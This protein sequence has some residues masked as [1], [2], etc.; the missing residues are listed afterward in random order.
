MRD[1]KI[2]LVSFTVLLV[3]SLLVPVEGHPQTATF[4]DSFDVS[5]EEN[6]VRGFAFSTDGTKMFVVG[7]SGDDVNEYTCTAFDVSTCV[8]V[9]SFDVS[10]QDTNPLDVAFS[11][12]GTTMIVLGLDGGDV[13]EYTLGTGFDV[14]TAA[15]VD[16]FII[17]GQEA[18]PTG[19]EFSTDGTT[20]FIVGSAV[21]ADVDEY[22]LGTG[23]D[24]ST[25]AFVDSFDVSGDDTLPTGL[26][27]SA[28]GTIMFVIGDAN[29]LVI[30]YDLGT[31]F[32]VSTTAPIFDAFDVTL[33]TI[34]PFD[35]EFSSD[36]KKMFVL[37]A[38][39]NFV[40]EYTVHAAFDL[41]APPPQPSSEGPTGIDGSAPTLGK[42]KFGVQLVENGFTF[43]GESVDVGRLYTDF[44]LISTDVGKL[45]N[46]QVKIFEN[47]GRGHIK[48]VEFA[49]GIPEVG[50]WYDAEAYIEVWIEQGG[51]KIKALKIFD[52]LNI[53]D[54]VSAFIGT[55]SCHSIGYGECLLV[56]LDYVY[57]ESPN[58]NVIGVK[59]ADFRGYANQF[60]FNDGVEVLG[61]SLNLPAKMTIAVSHADHHQQRGGTLELTQIDRYQNIW[62]D[63]YGIQWY[64]EDGRIKQITLPDYEHPQDKDNIGIQGMK[65]DHPL[66]E[67]Y[68]YEQQLKTMEIVKEILGAYA[69]NKTMPGYYLTSTNHDESFSEIND[70]VSIEYPE[71]HSG[72]SDLLIQQEISKAITILE[73]KCPKCNDQSFAELYNIVRFDDIPVD[74]TIVQEILQQ[75]YHD[76]LAKFNHRY[77]YIY[78]HDFYIIESIETITDDITRC[79]CIPYG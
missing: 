30:H 38:V 72:V 26:T 4:V 55:T 22:T 59:P 31:G 7:F 36:G 50:A 58:G 43:N 12:D 6:D 69:A 51:D 70:I 68:K 10:G 44:P 46:I 23:F 75:E 64:V 47:G 66:F 56:S 54:S 71:S 45:N 9:D 15:F 17:S 76:A 49:L 63:E 2:A 78:N 67:Q 74:D 61:E 39:T 18:T 34:D 24:V 32:D 5:G 21:P 62:E 8:F 77:G 25:A 48:Y 42:N 29:D 13:N 79:N 33:Q 73:Q 40:Y 16:S 3:T 35:V 20:M 27:F 41:W 65:R 28:D 37:G 53:I 11:S 14:S 1:T 57:R 52:D 19:L 60:F